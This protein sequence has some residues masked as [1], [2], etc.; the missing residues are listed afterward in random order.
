MKKEIYV[1]GNCKHLKLS[2]EIERI[3]S[4]VPVEWSFVSEESYNIIKDILDI[5]NLT[6]EELQA[7][8]NSIVRGLSS[9]I[10][11][12]SSYKDTDNWIKLSMV[13]GVIDH[14]KVDRGMEV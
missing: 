4:E 5:D 7:M 1:D 8:R 6:N 10:R 12:L 14:E 13:T 9:Y 3:V 11:G 2:N